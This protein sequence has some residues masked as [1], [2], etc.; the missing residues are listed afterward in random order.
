MSD[1]RARTRPALEHLLAGW[2]STQRSANTRAAYGGDLRRFAE[3]CTEQGV[4]PLD[5]STPE[6][7]R[8]RTTCEA[9][10]GSRAS[11]ARR[12]SAVGSFLRYAAGHGA[13]GAADSYADVRRPAAWDES[14]TAALSDDDAVALLEA[15]DAQHPKSALLVRLLMLD[16]LKVGEVVRADAGDLSGRPPRT[17]LRLVRQ[18]APHVLRLHAD[19]AGAARTYLGRRRSGPLLL[20]EGPAGG[21]RITRFGV[22]YL[23]KR[24]SGAA[25]LTISVSGNTLRRR[26]IERSHADGAEVDEIRRHVGHLDER[27]TRRYLDA[28]ET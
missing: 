17:S 8:F 13:P 28:D 9:A 24:A 7:Q 6:L 22:D 15:A 3:W 2:L 14:T 20:G 1:R 11:V 5:A 4:D 26:Y 16:G 25:G 10:G 12:L 23:V 21:D 19:T 18:R 27:T